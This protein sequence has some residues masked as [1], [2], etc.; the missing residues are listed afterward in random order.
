MHQAPQL[1]L[2]LGGRGRLSH[3]RSVSVCFHLEMVMPP[4]EG[5]APRRTTKVRRRNSEDVLTVVH[6]TNDPHNFT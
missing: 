1:K 5:G 2:V 6:P 4:I 3:V